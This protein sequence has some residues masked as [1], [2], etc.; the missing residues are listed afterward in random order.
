M[1]D[2][3]IYNDLK[4]IWSIKH[5]DTPFSLEGKN[6]SMYLHTPSNRVKIKD[7]TVEDNKVKWTFFGKDQKNTGKHS[8]ELVINEGE[9]GMITTDY[10]NFVNLVACSCKVGGTS[11]P[12]VE[13]ETIELTSNIEYIAGE[14]GAPYDDTEVRN[15]LSR[16]E[17]DKADKSE[18]TE[19]STQVGELSEDVANKVKKGSLATINGQSIENGGNIVIEGGQ[20]GTSSDRQ[21]VVKQTLNYN[22]ADNTYSVSN[23]VRGAIPSFFI[24]MVTEAGASFNAESGYFSLNGIDNIAYDEM[25]QIYDC[26]TGY[27][28]NSVLAIYGESYKAR[29]T[30]P[31]FRGFDSSFGNHTPTTAYCKYLLYKNASILT[32]AFCESNKTMCVQADSTNNFDGASVGSGVWNTLRL[33]EI[34]GIIDVSNMTKSANFFYNGAHSPYLAEFKLKSLK[35]SINISGMPRLSEAS[36]LYMINNEK[37][38]EG[39]TIKLHADAKAMADASE[40]I[41]SALA[42][43]TNITLGV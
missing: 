11:E 5:N 2:E 30:F 4:I 25:R 13:I 41:Q 12:N 31:I 16:L 21:G 43:H 15:E 3:R 7:F 22:T 27:G 36:L 26:R 34:I 18:L 37:S 10:C 42:T 23:V 28:C 35:A 1:K 6:V 40:A 20:G 17:R 39:I 19:L 29:T 14:G 9:E 38:T 8:L 32:C 33:E 24:D